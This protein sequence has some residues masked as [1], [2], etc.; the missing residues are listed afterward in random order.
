MSSRPTA[1]P[2]RR[3]HSRWLNHAIRPGSIRRSTSVWFIIPPVVVVVLEAVVLWTAEKYNP[4]FLSGNVWPTL[5]LIGSLGVTVWALLVK[6]SQNEDDARNDSGRFESRLRHDFWRAR[7]TAWVLVAVGIVSSG[8][9]L[10]TW[11]GLASAVPGFDVP[12][13]ELAVLV[14]TV[15]LLSILSRYTAMAF[16]TDVEANVAAQREEMDLLRT[17]YRLETSRLLD[18]NSEHWREQAASLERA[19]QSMKEVATLQRQTLQA[20]Q[21]TLATTGALLG[22]ERQREALRVEEARLRVQRIR[23]SVAIQGVIKH[24]GPI[25]KRIALRLFNQGED[26]RR[27]IVSLRHG[28][29]PANVVNRTVPSIAA[30]SNTEADFGDIDEW[31]DDVNFQAGVAVDDVDGNRYSCEAPLRYSRNRVIMSTPTFDPDDWQYPA[32]LPV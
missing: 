20:T 16:R 15:A 26:G 21:Q 9:V 18:R 2:P 12:F 8:L 1:S 25:A 32:M 22:L 30:F 6:I 17:S 24:P 3:S 14:L 31:A 23:P 5:L 28:P 19:I 10:F 11:S 29:D 7:T 13:V 4:A 27:L